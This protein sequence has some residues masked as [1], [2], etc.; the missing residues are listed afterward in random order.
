[1]SYRL[2]NILK[3]SKY[4]VTNH[5]SV[6]TTSSSSGTFVT[7]LGSE[8]SYKPSENASKVIYEISFYS[9][10]QGVTFTS[11]F[12]EHYVSGT[13]SEINQKYRKN[14]GLGGTNT[15]QMYRWPTYWRFVL[16]SWTGE[17]N[18]RIR[19]GHSAANRQIN[20]HQITDWDGAGSVTNRF[21]NT[22]LF[23]YSI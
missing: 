18:L 17:R 8:I 20:L 2:N 21:C 23:V 7:L 16:P 5:S 13:W 3:N 6:Q 9:E 22:S 15:N 4:L 14:W 1:M 11:A 12:L 19:L 10:K